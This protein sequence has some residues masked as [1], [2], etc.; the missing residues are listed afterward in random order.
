[1]ASFTDLNG[2]EWQ[3]NLDAINI[4]ACRS[5]LKFD[6]A[7]EASE[8]FPRLGKDPALLIQV[9][10]ELCRPQA[11]QGVEFKDFVTGFKGDQIESATDAL[12]KAYLDFSPPSKRKLLAAQM[13]VDGLLR[14]GATEKATTKISDPALIEKILAM[15]DAEMDKAILAILT[16]PSSPAS[17]PASVESVP[18][19]TRSAS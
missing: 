17:S 4:L 3:V 7:G 2:K 11:S 5:A 1:M 19:D 10:W 8:I 14:K 13:E 18:E 16:P 9:L 15:A 6:P 12:I